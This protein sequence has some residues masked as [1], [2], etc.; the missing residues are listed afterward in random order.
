MLKFCWNAQFQQSFG[1][2]RI[3]YR[4]NIW[5]NA[6]TFSEYSD[7]IISDISINF[8]LHLFII[9]WELFL[10]FRV[11]FES[12]IRWILGLMSKSIKIDI[13]SFV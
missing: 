13:V 7:K 4:E 12:Y 3:A 2:L 9:K 6:N 8:L 5:G 1:T 10:I 11:S